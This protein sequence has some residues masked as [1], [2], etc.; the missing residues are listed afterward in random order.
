MTDIV[1]RVGVDETAPGVAVTNPSS[2]S[3]T[4]PERM[5]RIAGR[6]G[7]VA[8]WTIAVDSREVTL[9]DELL[10]LFGLRSHP[11][12]DLDQALEFYRPADRP[13]V[14]A[15]LERCIAD[16]TPV[17][18]ELLIDLPDGRTA[19]V[20][21]LGEAQHDA[22]GRITAVHG[23]I[24]DITVHRT[25][26]GR[27]RE[28]ASLLDN[29]TDAILV[30]DLDGIVSYWNRAAEQ[31]YGWTAAEAVG[32]HIADLVD[33][34]D[35]ERYRA[36]EDVIWADGE[37]SGQLDNVDR[38]GRRVVIELHVNTIGDE[39]GRP[40]AI[41]S[42]ASDITRRIELEQ[43]LARAQKLEAVG[44]LTGGVAHD[45]NNLLTVIAGSSEL[46]ADAVAGDDE[47]AELVDMIRAASSR[48]ADLTRRL[49]AYARRQ[50][51]RPE[52]LAPGAV[53]EQMLAL[54]RRSFPEAITITFDAP[55]DTGLVTADPGQ[56][57]AALMNVALNA[58]DAMGG[59]G[60][61][62]ISVDTVT[63]ASDPGLEIEAGE[64]VRIAVRDDGAGMTPE[65]RE[66]AFD[67]FFTTKPTGEG[68][69]LGLSM[70]YGFVRQSGGHVELHSEP[71]A[72]TTIELLLP[73]HP[74]QL[75][76]AAPTRTDDT[77][78]RGTERILVVED[79]PLVRAQ[80]LTGL[81]RLGYDVVEA[82]DASEALARLQATGATGA[83]GFDLV[84]S[85]VVMPGPMDGF[86]LAA[87]VDRRW[88]D[89][90]VLLT[91]GYADSDRGTAADRRALLH[92]PYRRATL[93]QTVRRILDGRP[94]RP[95]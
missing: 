22:D 91:S 7:R 67:P 11:V 27:L 26:Q 41:F 56:L 49:L 34:G 93:A 17:D 24:A 94:S 8:A 32:R 3:L 71:G 63:L 45:F 14:L 48:G 4:E 46:L 23:A 58:R 62:H 29:A 66:R 57:E 64:Y 68:S 73:R 18:R 86:E 78:P 31:L 61:L 21:V 84:F 59:R 28:Q 89:T 76:E 95:R 55:D 92:K 77:M 50:P 75:A 60:E 12:V 47:L 37:W 51:L 33:G 80:T 81:G 65:I 70:V 87:E 40:V 39:H 35:M 1:V 83:P 43:R 82:A 44:Q 54:L 9:S 52:T 16:G 88:P 13:T 20:R 53:V 5:R 69:G 36:I 38:D 90:P 10:E 30:R 15:D 25:T 2:G 74:A 19:W 42:I 79:D 72:G 6:L 85:D